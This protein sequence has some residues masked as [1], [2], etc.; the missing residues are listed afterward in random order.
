[1]QVFYKNN[2]NNY[3]QKIKHLILNKIIKEIFL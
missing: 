3:N 1:M 2:K